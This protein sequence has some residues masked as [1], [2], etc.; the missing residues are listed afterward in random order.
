MLDAVCH[1]NHKEIDRQHK[2][3]FSLFDQCKAA[4]EEKNNKKVMIIV[5]DLVKYG[6]EHFR[7]EEDAMIYSKYPTKLYDEHVFQHALFKIKDD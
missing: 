4:L 1:L 7:Y 6:I 3:L 5:N 2:V